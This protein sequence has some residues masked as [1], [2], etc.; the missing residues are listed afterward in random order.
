MIPRRALPIHLRAVKTSTGGNT[1]LKT[2][3]LSHLL[4]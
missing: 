2:R 4:F 3:V 1:V